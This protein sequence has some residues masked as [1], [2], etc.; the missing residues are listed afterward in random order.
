MVGSIAYVSHD[1]KTVTVVDTYCDLG[2]EERETN[3][4]YYRNLEDA[5]REMIISLREH[6]TNI[7]DSIKRIEDY[8][9]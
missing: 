6:V 9:E 4:T 8:Q 2:G 1:E 5:K 3:R 7:E